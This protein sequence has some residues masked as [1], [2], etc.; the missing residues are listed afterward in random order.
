MNKIIRLIPL[1]AVLALAS[2]NKFLD[3]M[4]DNRTEIDS[5]EHVEK[6]LVSAYPEGTYM[7]LGEYMSDNV[8][9]HGANNP[10]SNR[11]YNQVYAWQDVTET[12]NDSP[13]MLWQASYNAIA[14]A[15][16][17]LASIDEMGGATTQALREARGEALLCRAYNHFILTNMFCLHYAANDDTSLGIPYAT[18]PETTLSP[19]YERGTV[20]EDYEQMDRDL[21]EGLDLVGESYYTVPKYHFN[22]KAAYAFATRFYLYYEQYDKAIAYASK[23]LGS[24]PQTMLRDYK[25]QSTMTQELSAIRL[26]YIEPAQNT[27]L[28]LATAYS[29]IGWA[30]GP[31][32]EGKRYSHGAYI[33]LHEDANAVNV[34]GVVGWYM[35]LK[36]YAATNREYYIFWRTPNIIQNSYART[37]YPLFTA[38]EVLL[39][40]AEAYIMQRRFD[41]AAS[42]LTVWL[43]NTNEEASARDF[44]LTPDS[45]ANFYRN[46]DYSYTPSPTDPDGIGS[47][48][49]KHLHPSFAIDAE[50]SVQECMLQL[51]LCCRRIETLGL[52][53]RW[54]DIKRWGIEIPRRQ[55]DATANPERINDWLRKDDLRRAVQIP[56]KVV[57]AGLPANPR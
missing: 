18:E 40:R 57:N 41:E 32:T 29:L 19:Q 4:P 27:N 42:D 17:A 30:F 20:K 45:I 34:W 28:I 22:K 43:H 25:A 6:L 49:K 48:I 13:E 26:H 47:T 51:T 11:F 56:Q 5:E 31:Y 9:D 7:L 21:S 33:A 50:G 35:G 16:Q 39:D 8:D 3:E 23:V 15:N 53:R 2:C 55:L 14:A 44:R 10:Y 24:S 37:A 54:F 52:G 46:V 36:E 12:E 38:D 1:C